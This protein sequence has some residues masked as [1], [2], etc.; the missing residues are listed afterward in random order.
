[1]ADSWYWVELHTKVQTVSEEAVQLRNW[2][3]E[4][5]QIEH[6]SHLTLLVFQ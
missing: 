2:Y 3:C 6:D 5:W 4:A 1:M